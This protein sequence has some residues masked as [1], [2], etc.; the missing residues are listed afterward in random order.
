MR[1]FVLI[2]HGKSDRLSIFETDFWYD[3]GQQVIT[4]CEALDYKNI[5]LVDT[6][7]G[8][9]AA[10]NVALE[11]P[12]LV[13]KLIADSFEGTHSVEHFAGQVL[14]ERSEAKSQESAMMF[15]HYMH[16]DNWQQV[17][18]ADTQMILQHHQ[19]ISELKVPTLFIGSLEDEYCPNIENVFTSLQHQVTNCQVHLFSTG[20]HPSI[21]NSPSD[22]STIAKIFFNTNDS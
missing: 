11:R 5:H 15:W 8:T 3:Q 6:S 19:N 17:V 16:G 2:F 13:S 10:I 22:F 20:N 12:D 7:G 9:L 18:D 4:F 21:I 14:Q 1:L